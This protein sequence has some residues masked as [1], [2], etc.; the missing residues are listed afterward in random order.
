MLFHRKNRSIHH[1]K[2]VAFLSGKQ[3][4][5]AD[6]IRVIRITIEF[7]KGFIAFYNIGPAVTVFG[8]ARF[9]ESHKYYEIAKN[10]GRAL[11]QR[12]YTVLTG[13]GPGLM[14]AANRGSM[15]ANGISIGAN[16][17]LPEE[18]LPNKYVSKL[19]TFYYF[20]VRKVI[21][22]KY[23]FAYV[24]LPG[25]FGTLDELAESI[26][27]I[28]TKKLVQFPI[29]LVGEEYWKG[30]LDWIKDILLRNNAVDEEDIS[31]LYLTDSLD[32]VL[33][34]IDATA[35]LFNIKSK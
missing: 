35:K 13:G 17:I 11:A 12:G 15:E 27:L 4:L 2:E 34:T 28:Q 20:F 5:V 22:L 3:G 18:Q 6:F 29:I 25:G 16:I 10:L 19:V 1:K 30:F 21:L 9:K 32:D 26:T 14:E 8:S 33:K 23:S 24:F 31:I 7:M